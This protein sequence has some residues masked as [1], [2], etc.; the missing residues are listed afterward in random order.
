MSDMQP[1]PNRVAIDGPSASGKSTIGGLLA[2]RWQCRFLDTGIMYRCVTHFALRQG[3]DLSDDDSLGDLAESLQFGLSG[4]RGSESVLT[5]QGEVMSDQLHADEVTSAVSKVSAV[6]MVREAMVSQQRSIGAQGEIV[7]A[8]RD[9]GTVVMPDADFKVYLDAS[10]HARA[11]RRVNYNGKT[12]T[13]AAFNEILA[14]IERRDQYDSSRQHSPLARAADAVYLRTD[15]FTVTDTLNKV[16][17]IYNQS[18]G[19]DR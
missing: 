2:A 13:A 11:M 16:V 10:A 12:D 7:M 6:G 15:D 19:S 18:V 8:G 4:G 9:I 3:V 1:K 17:E 14:S 5:V